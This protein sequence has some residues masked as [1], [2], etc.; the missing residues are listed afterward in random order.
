MGQLINTNLCPDELRDNPEWKDCFIIHEKWLIECYYSSRG[1]SSRLSD[2]FDIVCDTEEE[3]NTEVARLY[4]EQKRDNRNRIARYE[5]EMRMSVM[6]ETT[7]DRE[8]SYPTMDKT[9]YKVK[10]Y[11]TTMCPD[12]KRYH[13]LIYEF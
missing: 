11:I 1:A 13:T 10:K 8:P 12:G 7:D 2:I 6:D 5:R 4:A 3:A 9:V